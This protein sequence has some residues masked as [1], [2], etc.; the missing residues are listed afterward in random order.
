MSSTGRSPTLREKLVKIGARIVRHGR[1]VVFQLAEVAVPRASFAEFCAGSMACGYGRRR[2]RHRI[3]SDE[4]RPSK[5]GASMID[6]EPLPR[7]DNS[8][9]KPQNAA[10]GSLAAR[11]GARMRLAASGEP[12][13]DWRS[14][15]GKWGIPV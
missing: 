9:R 10:V 13:H 11:P 6:L 3:R 12:P 7:S 4:R 8:G 1:Y 14:G 15:T 2:S 5:R